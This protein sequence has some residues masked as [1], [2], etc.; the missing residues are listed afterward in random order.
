MILL[1]N[2]D[3]VWCIDMLELF[4]TEQVLD[5]I[6]IETNTFAS[7][8]LASRTITRKS[9]LG[10]WCATDKAEIK[11]FIGIIKPLP[12]SKLYKSELNPDSMERDQF[13]ILMRRSL[14]LT[15]LIPTHIV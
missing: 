12:K 4:V 7:Q 2:T 9:R 3:K 8:E 15:T 10:K 11:K 13:L 6:I 1:A 5:L 14:P